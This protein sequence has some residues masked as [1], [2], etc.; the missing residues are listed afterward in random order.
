MQTVCVSGALGGR[1]GEAAAAEDARHRVRGGSDGL[2]PHDRPHVR[3]VRAHQNQVHLIAALLITLLDS[4]LAVLEPP[5]TSA[6]RHDGPF[7]RIL[8]FLRAKCSQRW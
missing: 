5:N 1:G 4:F 8:D 6:P 2:E 7:E 3:R